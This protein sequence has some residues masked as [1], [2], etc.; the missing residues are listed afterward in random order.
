M[1]PTTTSRRSSAGFWSN[2]K[3]FFLPVGQHIDGSAVRGYP[4]DMR[5]KAA[6]PEG[7]PEEY[8]GAHGLHV[9]ATQYALGCYERWLSGDGEQWLEASI[10]TARRLI[11]L[12]SEDGSWLHHEPFAHTFPLPA[13]WASGITQ[14]QGASL[15][16]RL[17]Q[18]TRD[19]EFAHAAEL[20]LA[21]LTIPQAD[22]GVRG[23]LGGRP[24]PEEYPTS[25]QS[26][27]LNG[28]I[29]ALWGFRDVAVGLGNPEAQRDFDEGIDSLAL[30]LHRYDTGSWSLYSLFPHPI[31]NRASSFYHDL[32]VRQLTAMQTFAPRP[33]FEAMRRKWAAYAESRYSQATSF[34]WKAAFRLIVPRNPRLARALPWS[35][36]YQVAG[37]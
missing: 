25:P 18:E 14:G 29:F 35:H 19:P 32:H 8:W 33:E 22:G 7:L 2:A 13:P 16:V 28:A 36:L 15:L 31:L 26:H 17:H 9:A 30:N 37:V 24:W 4:I 27:V 23:D 10:A 6:S 21:P 34:A 3:T 5:V 20:A 11:S 1:T 12:Q